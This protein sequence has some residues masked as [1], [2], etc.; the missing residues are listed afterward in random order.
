MSNGMRLVLGDI[1]SRF[2]HVFLADIPDPVHREG[3]VPGA[4]SGSRQYVFP[5]GSSPSF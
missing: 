5:Q 3:F 2:L 4:R 1:N